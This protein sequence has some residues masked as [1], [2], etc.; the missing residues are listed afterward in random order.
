MRALSSKKE[1]QKFE[2]TRIDY[3]ENGNQKQ[4]SNYADNKLNGTQIDWYE[5]NEKKSEKEITWNPIKKISSVKIVQFWNKDKKQTVVDGN[6][7]YE[8]TN[9]NIYEKGEIK[10]GE[11]QGIWEGKN[12][13]KKYSFTENY[14]E[15][16]FISG[17]STDE[18]NKQF[19]YK[20]IL[21]KPFPAKGMPDFYKHIGKNFNTPKVEGLQGKIYLSFVVDEDGNPTD[22]KIL[23]DIGYGTGVESI[24]AVTSYGK[25]IPG[26]WRGIP[27]RVM[28]SLPITI[29]ASQATKNARQIYNEQLQR[30]NDPFQQ[31]FNQF[32]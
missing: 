30:S 19:H 5:N 23:R 15:G 4:E 28:Y 22:F 21:E 27:A 20:E 1:E 8:D 3:Y 18:N 10:N 7:F 9:D 25:W 29:Q 13:K 2:G 16:V 26:K 31:N 12:L 14:N 11:K 24:K 32:R 6:G 17:I